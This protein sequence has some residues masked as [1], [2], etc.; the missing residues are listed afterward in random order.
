[1]DEQ[2]ILQILIQVIQEIQAWSGDPL[3][4]IDEETIPITDIAGFDSQRAIE[5]TIQFDIRLGNVLPDELKNIFVS[6]HKRPLPIR[7]IVKQIN[8]L[9]TKREKTK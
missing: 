7:E 3:E 6:E 5:T 8:K 1:M 9:M 2:S 4:D